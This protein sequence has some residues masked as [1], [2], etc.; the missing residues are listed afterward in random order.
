MAFGALI[1]VGALSIISRRRGADGRLVLAALSVYLFGVSGAQMIK[2][3]RF[4][5]TKMNWVF[6]TMVNTALISSYFAGRIVGLPDA[7]RDR[8]AA[9]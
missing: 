7:L 2:K 1:V 3:F 6:A 8:T 4:R 9:Q 5:G